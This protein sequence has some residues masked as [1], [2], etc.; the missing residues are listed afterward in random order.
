MARLIQGGARGGEATPPRR[1]RCFVG[2]LVRRHPLSGAR[3]P[4]VVIVGRHELVGPR[5]ALERSLAVALEHL[6][7]EGREPS[8]TE[9]NFSGGVPGEVLMAEEKEQAKGTATGGRIAVVLGA[10]VTVLALVAAA[11]GHLKEIVD[12]LRTTFGSDQAAKIKDSPPLPP[13]APVAKSPAPGPTP[14]DRADLVR[15]F[16]F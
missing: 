4:P 5:R 14:D 2:E 3:S 13:L 1:G 9:V 8:R 11:T 15:S 6:V 10:V 16:Y 12:N 7:C